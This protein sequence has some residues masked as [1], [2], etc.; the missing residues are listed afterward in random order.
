MCAH[1][2]ANACRLFL[3]VIEHGNNG[4]R[5]MLITPEGLR[6]DE[7][8]SFALELKRMVPPIN[9]AFEKALRLDYPVDQRKEKGKHVLF[10]IEVASSEAGKRMVH[11]PSS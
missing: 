2:C 1:R 10:Y 7:C 11:H 4:C 8:N 3:E 5:G 9:M 6:G